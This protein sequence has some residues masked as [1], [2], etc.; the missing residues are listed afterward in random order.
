MRKNTLK[1]HSTLWR[2]KSIAL[3][4]KE[5]N[6]PH[7][8]SIK[9]LFTKDNASIHAIELRKRAQERYCLELV[10]FKEDYEELVL[11]EDQESIKLVMFTMYK[12]YF[13]KSSSNEINIQA[14]LSDRFKDTILTE[15]YD[16]QV[17]KDIYMEVIKMLI[18]NGIIE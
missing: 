5:V 18:E 16:K 17:L 1:R 10:L 9:S 6:D 4:D 15:K 13:S 3:N 14:K 11:L 8:K 12:K 7:Y 2:P